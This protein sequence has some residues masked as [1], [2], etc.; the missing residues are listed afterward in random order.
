MFKKE[1]IAW[2]YEWSLTRFAFSELLPW[3]GVIMHT[4]AER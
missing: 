4:Y 1:P 2:N 3:T